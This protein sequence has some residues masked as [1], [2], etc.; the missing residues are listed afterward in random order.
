MVQ[1]LNGTIAGAY[2]LLTP[3]QI[4][5][6][7]KTTG[8]LPIAYG[9][10]SVVERDGSFAD[11]SPEDLKDILDMYV[12]YNKVVYENV[13]T[14][15]LQNEELTK[16]YKQFLFTEKALNGEVEIVNDELDRKMAA[17]QKTAKR[18]AADMVKSNSAALNANRKQ[19]LNKKRK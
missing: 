5:E 15:I 8:D 1:I 2:N 18:I 13:E 3:E 10:V 16:R 14:I 7:F 6:K 4:V 19:F 9:L 12:R 11:L 17:S